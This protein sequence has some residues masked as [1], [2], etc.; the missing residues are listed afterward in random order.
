M[1]MLQRSKGRIV[2]WNGWR[3]KAEVGGGVLQG[4]RSVGAKARGRI[5]LSCQG[6]HGGE[7][8]LNPG[9]ES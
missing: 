9:L 5:A 1:E 6:K 8:G 7:Q 2:G 4:V 3:E